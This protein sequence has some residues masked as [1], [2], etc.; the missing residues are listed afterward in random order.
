MNRAHRLC[1]LLKAESPQSTYDLWRPLGTAPMR[2]F[3]EAK[4]AGLPVEN[5]LDEKGEPVYHRH[6]GAN[7]AVYVYKRELKQLQLIQ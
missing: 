6:N 5:L 7:Y 3:H 1:E 2:A 4:K